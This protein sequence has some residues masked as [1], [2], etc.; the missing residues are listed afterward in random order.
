MPQRGRTAL[1]AALEAGHLE[2]VKILLGA[3]ADLTARLWN[4][5]SILELAFDLRI[6]KL[7][8]SAALVSSNPEYLDIDSS[9]VL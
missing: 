1:Q 8:R 4:G 5:G 7:L 3:E 6:M 2:V 9:N